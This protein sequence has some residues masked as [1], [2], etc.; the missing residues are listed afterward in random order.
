[1]RDCIAPSLHKLYRASFDK[2]KVPAI[3]KKANVTPIFKKGDKS[4]ANN[5]RP[6][7]LLSVPG[8]LLEKI[9]FKHIFNHLRDNAILSQWQSGFLPGCSTICQLLEIYHKFCHSVE[10]GKEVR[11][12]FLDISR[13]FDRVWHAG[14]LYKLKRIGIDGCLLEWIKDYLKDRQQRVCLEGVFSDW[15]SILAGVPQGSILGPLLF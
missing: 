9:V 7:S 14:L 1:M 4:D 8:K 6:V 13:A 5:Y 12:I 15:C 2:H 10:S 11:V 3:W